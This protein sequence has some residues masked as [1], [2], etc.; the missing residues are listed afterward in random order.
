L[1][2]GDLEGHVIECPWHASRFDVTTGKVLRGPAE[3]PLK[4][5]KVALEG[6]IGRVEEW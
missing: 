1:N 5:Y 4:T 3:D 6:E 2:E